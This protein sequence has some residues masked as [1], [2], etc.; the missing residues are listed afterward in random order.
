MRVGLITCIYSYFFWYII[1][2]LIQLYMTVD[3]ISCKSPVLLWRKIH[4]CRT[5]VHDRRSVDRITRYMGC[6]APYGGLLISYLSS[7]WCKKPK[8]ASLSL[9]RYRHFGLG[10]QQWSLKCI[11]EQ[12]GG[13]MMPHH[14][15]GW[16]SMISQAGWSQNTVSILSLSGHLRVAAEA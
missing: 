2:Y 9:W 14:S 11:M 5:I 8:P 1:R 7:H 15:V 16:R 4:V 12:Y 3:P 10:P 13:L 6:I